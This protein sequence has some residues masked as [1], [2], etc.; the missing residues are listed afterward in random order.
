MPDSHDTE[1]PQGQDSVHQSSTPSPQMERWLRESTKE[2]P[3]HLRSSIPV[4]STQ[5]QTTFNPSPYTASQN[6]AAQGSAN[7][8]RPSLNRNSLKYHLG[9]QHEPVRS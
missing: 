9:S 1:I 7:E 6:P 8:T 5:T 2:M 3:F 4:S